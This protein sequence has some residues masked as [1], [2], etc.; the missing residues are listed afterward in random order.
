[1][2]RRTMR[3]TRFASTR[4]TRPV[5]LCWTDMVLP[6]SHYMVTPLQFIPMTVPRSGPAHIPTDPF[7]DFELSRLFA[8]HQ[9]RIDPAA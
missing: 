6:S 7:A 5:S 4:S 8:G 9:V 1:M 2:P 3:A